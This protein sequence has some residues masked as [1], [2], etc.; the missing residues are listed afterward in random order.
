MTDSYLSV[1]QCFFIKL[2][3]YVHC[4]LVLVALPTLME[5]GYRMLHTLF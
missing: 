3:S 1:A 4:L 2:L 5:Q